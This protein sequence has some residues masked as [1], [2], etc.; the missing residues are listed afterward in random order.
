MNRKETKTWR[1][2]SMLQTWKHSYD[3]NCRHTRRM[4]T[5]TWKKI[6]L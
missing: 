6:V 1:D 3:K 2:F 5:Y 4:K